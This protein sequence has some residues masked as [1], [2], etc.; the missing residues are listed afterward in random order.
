MAIFGIKVSQQ[1]YEVETSD[2]D[3]THLD[4]RY[5]SL[6]LL[7]KKTVGF[8]AS[9]GQ[10]SPTGTIS[11]SHPYGFATL[12]LGSVDFEDS[13]GRLTIPYHYVDPTDAGNFQEVD[14]ALEITDTTIDV[15]WSVKEYLPGEEYPLTESVTATITLDI[16]ALELGSTTE[17]S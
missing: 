10:T 16:Y 11:Y 13:P 17:T 5:Q 14:I 1:G 8:V 2:I 15:D 7:E 9:I 12:V 4:S 3:T 6:M